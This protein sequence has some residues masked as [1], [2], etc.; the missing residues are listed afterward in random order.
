MAKPILLYTPIFSDTAESIT[1][2]LFDFPA[3][4]EIEIWMNTPGGS[5]SAGWS[6]LAA[7]NELKRDVNVTVLGDAQSFGF[8][9]LLFANKVKGYDTSNFMIHRAASFWEDVMTDEELKEIEDRNKIIRGKL[10]VRIKEDKFKEI[11]GKSFDDI[12]SMDD[13]LDV[14]LTAKQAK[15]IGLIDE[16][17]SL[18]VKKRK[19]IESRYYDEIM[20]LSINSNKKKMGKLTDLIFGE[21][22]PVL[23]AQI[24]E[25][26]FAYSKLEMGAKIKAVGKGDHEPISGT[27]EAEN[28]TVTVVE[29]EITAITEIDKSGQEIEALKAEIKALKENQITVEDVAEVINKL[30]DEQASELNAI[31]E[32]LEKAKLAVSKPELPEGEFVDEP[33]GEILSVRERLTALQ[34]EKHDQKRKQRE[35]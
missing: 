1:R 2:Q 33:V 22:D 27:F 5:V 32:I 8:F 34:N 12:F 24:G 28:K 29:N 35:E 19:E 25:T 16:V 9:M 23:I 21:K 4:E 11:T 30:Q 14:N 10:E 17:I 13:R 7:L 6:I 3:N 26:Q 20:A 15:E 31:R 18:D